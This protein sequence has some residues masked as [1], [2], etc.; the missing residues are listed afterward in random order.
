MEF[1]KNKRENA[2]FFI[3]GSK[4]QVSHMGGCNSYQI[5]EL[6]LCGLFSHLQSTIYIEHL[7]NW[8]IMGIILHNH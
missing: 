6:S 3:K 1:T 5:E 4:E 2:V 8:E 7:T